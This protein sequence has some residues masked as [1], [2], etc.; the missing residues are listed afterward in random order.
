M[1][2]ILLIAFFT[3]PLHSKPPQDV[4]KLKAAMMRHMMVY[5]HIAESI[6]RH[7]GYQFQLDSPTQP[8]N[9]GQSDRLANNGIDLMPWFVHQTVG[10]YSP[11]DGPN[12]WNTAINFNDPS[13]GVKHT[14]MGEMIRNLEEEYTKIDLRKGHVLQMGDIIS[15]WSPSFIQFRELL[16]S[17]VYLGNGIT[18]DKHTLEKNSPYVFSTVKAAF[19]LY[20]H[21]TRRTNQKS[22][23]KYTV[24]RKN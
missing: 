15:L 7:P 10:T 16:H 11:V 17:T 21:N 1:R 14:T 22:M 9:I 23:Y 3:L 6:E 13:I 19:D 24:H 12:C 8:L 5:H 4:R 18:F 20:D 2:Y